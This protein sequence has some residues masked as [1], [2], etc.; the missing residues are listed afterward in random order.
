MDSE[1]GA[2]MENRMKYYGERRSSDNV[3]VF[4]WDLSSVIFFEVE[5][6][7]RLGKTL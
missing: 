7:T 5:H 4:W 3:M 6:S 1:I 2:G